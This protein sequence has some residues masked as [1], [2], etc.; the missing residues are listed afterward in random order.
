MLHGKLAPGGALSAAQVV[1][2]TEAMF[3]IGEPLRQVSIA[4][5]H[6]YNNGRKFS[7]AARRFNV[8]IAIVSL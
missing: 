4:L 2:Y 5:Q 3:E 1:A 8:G 7:L 6:V